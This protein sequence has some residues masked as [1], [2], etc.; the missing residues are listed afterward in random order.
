MREVD[1]RRSAR[2]RARQNVR[3]L[4]RLARRAHRYPQR[5]TARRCCVDVDVAADAD[6]AAADDRDHAFAD[7]DVV[8]A[9]AAIAAVVVVDHLP[10]QVL[11]FH[12]LQSFA[13][14]HRFRRHGFRH[15]LVAVVVAFVVV[16]HLTRLTRLHLDRPT[17]AMQRVLARQQQQAL[18]QSRQSRSQP[19][20]C[21]CEGGGA[22]WAPP[23]NHLEK[24]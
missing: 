2:F 8:A 13:L 23:L 14:R 19:S 22:L 17:A 12:R 3:R 9:A 21:A 4:V 15:D 16:A 18:V 24:G 5:P 11:H 7:D 6:V 10:S 1:L 20:V